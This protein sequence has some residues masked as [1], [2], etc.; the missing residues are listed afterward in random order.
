MELRLGLLSGLEVGVLISPHSLA[1]VFGSVAAAAAALNCSQTL[2]VEFSGSGSAAEKPL[3]Q[4]AQ[5][6]HIQ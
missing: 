5:L 4:A 6:L 1:R 3:A 2:H